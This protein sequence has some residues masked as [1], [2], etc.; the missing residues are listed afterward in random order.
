MIIK[1]ELYSSTGNQRYKTIVA[2]N[3]RR[4][5]GV[6]LA[7]T[8]H[9][10]VIWVNGREY[11]II[12]RSMDLRE[13]VYTRMCEAMENRQ[14]HITIDLEE[15][16]DNKLTPELIKKDIKLRSYKFT[17]HLKL[18]A[19]HIL[20]SQGLEFDQLRTLDAFKSFS[21]TQLKGIRERK[22]LILN[23]EQIINLSKTLRYPKEFHNYVSPAAFWHNLYELRTES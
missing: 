16:Y 20:S 14:L 10:S 6:I 12:F 4:Q 2:N 7:H 3:F 22:N 19:E 11:P 18:C 1:Q 13:K 23:D 5:D 21:K 17:K 9:S 8:K 15:F